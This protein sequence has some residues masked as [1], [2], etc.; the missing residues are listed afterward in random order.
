MIGDYCGLPGSARPS[1]EYPLPRPTSS[2][3]ISTYVDGMYPSFPLRSA[4]H[5]PS[6]SC[7]ITRILS[8]F[9][10]DSSRE[11]LALKSYSPLQYSSRAFGGAFGFGRG[12]VGGG[13]WFCTGVGLVAAAVFAAANAAAPDVGLPAVDAGGAG[14]GAGVLDDTGR[15]RVDCG[16]VLAGG[17]D[18]VS[19]PPPRGG[20]GAARPISIFFDFTL[21]P[22]DIP[23][24]RSGAGE[25]DIFQSGLGGFL[26]D[27]VAGLDALMKLPN[28][29]HHTTPHHHTNQSNHHKHDQTNSR[30]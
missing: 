4:D 9:L 1:D 2:S 23:R 29:P 3:I 7:A 10:N 27:I 5:H 30:F 25:D 16:A 12:A 21:T 6:S 18:L 24:D 19:P 20:G 13:G 11:S 17:G 15:D 14:F 28:T 26:L 22:I 8:P